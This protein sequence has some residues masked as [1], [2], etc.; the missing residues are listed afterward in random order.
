MP[1]ND[2]NDLSNTVE[3][4]RK[5]MHPELDGAF[6]DAVVLAEEEN[7]DNDVEAVNAIRSALAM[8]LAPKAVG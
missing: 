2:L 7:A 5:E 6:L 3:A 1:T 4:I 8:V